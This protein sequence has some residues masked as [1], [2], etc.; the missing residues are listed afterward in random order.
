MYLA[1][2]AFVGATVSASAVEGFLFTP[3]VALWVL[4]YALGG[5]AYLL[6]MA[7]LRRS[8]QRVAETKDEQLDERQRSIRDRAYR[9]A[10]TILTSLTMLALIYLS[11]AASFEGLGLWLP[12]R[13][14]VFAIVTGFILL[15]TSLPTAVI[16]WNE[17]DPEGDDA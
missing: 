13:Q 6:T 17:P 1:L 9:S 3:G 14:S 5:L 12:P 15:S 7:V 2:L 11:Y 10:Y 4:A 8:T 16:A